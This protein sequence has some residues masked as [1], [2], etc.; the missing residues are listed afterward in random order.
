MF[1]WNI[2]GVTFLVLQLKFGKISLNVIWQ[3]VYNTKYSQSSSGP[4]K[5]QRRKN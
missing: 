2:S 5:K 3:E 1:I 4:S